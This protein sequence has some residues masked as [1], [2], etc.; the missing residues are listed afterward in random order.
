MI[1][2]K[3]HKLK[4]IK[5]EKKKSKS[6]VREGLIG[7]K[8]LKYNYMTQNQIE[9][10]R[11]IINKYTKR[12]CKIWIK[13]YYLIP[14]TRKNIS[15][16]MGKGIGK[17]YKYIYII[18]KGMIIFELLYSTLLLKNVMKNTLLIASHKLP[19]STAIY[20]KKIKGI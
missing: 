11:K 13:V 6:F 18:K 20:F 5:E 8:A 3:Q 10:A 7:L 19:V 17:I 15:A 12:N 2:Q 16:R 9:S 14:Q 1:K 4:F